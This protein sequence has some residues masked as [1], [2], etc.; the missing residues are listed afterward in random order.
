VPDAGV[1]LDDR[2][3]VLGLGKRLCSN[4]GAGRFGW[5]TF[6]KLMLTKNG[7]SGC[8]AA[9]SRNLRPDCS[10]YLSRKGMPT[11]PFSGVST[12][13]PLT[14][15]SSLASSPALPESDPFEG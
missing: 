10:T 11:T 4:S 13:S 1:E 12:A 7:W 8:F 3:G 9:S 6:I 5:W 15:Q 2:V 14:F